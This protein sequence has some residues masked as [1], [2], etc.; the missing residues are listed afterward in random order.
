MRNRWSDAEAAGQSELELLA[1]TSRLIGQEPALVIA[2]GGNTSLKQ[3]ETDYRGRRV[4]VLRVKGSGSDLAAVAAKDFPGV[5]MD[6][7]LPLLEREQLDDREMMRYLTHTLME[8]GSPRPSIETLLHAFLPWNAIHHSHADAALVLADNARDR[9]LIRECFG[10]EV[11]IVPYIIPGFRL[12]KVAYQAVMAHGGKPKGAI[13][14]NHGL[15]SWGDTCK[16]SYDRHIE[17]ATRLEEFAAARR[18]GR[19]VFAARPERTLSAA[20]RQSAAARLAPVLRGLLGGGERVVM[21]YDDS[22]PVLHFVGDP[23]AA[24]LSQVGAA[25]PD[26][27]LNTKRLPLLIDADPRNHAALVAAV[28][29]G[30][31]RYVADYQAYVAR[32]NHEHHPMLDPHPRVVLVAGLGLF[33]QGRDYRSALL[34]QQIYQHTIGIIEQAEAVG[35]YRA[36]GEQDAFAA[37]YFPLELDKLKSLPPQK[38][39]ARRVALVTG[40]A[41]GIGKAVAARFAAEGAQVLLTDIDPTALA[42]AAAEL[43]QTYGKGRCTPI[44]MDVTKEE[45]VEQA[46]R[47]AV[48]VYG[49]IDVIF[50]NAGIAPTGAIHD[51]D[52]ATWQRSFA[53]NTHG[54]FLVSRAAVRIMR[55]QRLGGSIVF[56]VT[57]NVLA[58]GK[59]FGAY[60]AAKAAEAQLCRVLAI[61]HGG[62]KIRV[63]MLHPDAVMTDL[64]SPKVRADRAKA[65]GIK[66]EELPAYLKGRT[67]LKENV[68]AEDVAEA[69]LFFA[70]DRSSKSTGNML[71]VDAGARESFPR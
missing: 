59:D 8:P 31:D 9:E 12:S 64:W 63:N 49:G 22:E 43:N 30:V 47:Q 13:L 18:A 53:I 61:E 2:G 58:A 33:T 42:E 34:P 27:M 26:H 55:Q 41:R 37:E 40:G 60:S 25:T 57:K 62:E 29:A 4:R 20:E 68:L 56:N 46:F 17:L 69:A 66:E 39:L 45:S 19:Q 3:E 5:R 24:R 54:H 7:V 48:L 71:V 50:S 36:L 35:E 52:F 21:L 28:Q 32:C 14:L 67:L 6:D 23:D 70:S 38:E 15:F 1:Y 51:L 44:V 11:A 10:D 16:E 65:Y